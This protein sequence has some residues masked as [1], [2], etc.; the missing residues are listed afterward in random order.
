MSQ[1]ALGTD[2]PARHASRL[3]AAHSGSAG[4]PVG[5][6]AVGPCLTGQ[7]L[8]LSWPG[9]WPPPRNLRPSWDP[10]VGPPGPVPLP[11]PTPPRRNF[12]CW[13]KALLPLAVG[14]EAGTGRRLLTALGPGA[15]RLRGA[16]QGS[17]RPRHRGGV[18]S[19]EL[20]ASGVQSDCSQVPAQPLLP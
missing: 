11:P 12:L 14:A 4:P 8:A 2:S 6:G 16:A 19:P 5:G 15:P 18:G 1:R 9:R 10:C 7:H 13:A 17:K 3:A 20:P